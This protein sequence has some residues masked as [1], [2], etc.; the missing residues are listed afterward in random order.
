MSESCAEWRNESNRWSDADGHWRT[1]DGCYLVFDYDL[2]AC[3][4]WCWH[5]CTALDDVKGW[6]RRLTV[7]VWVTSNVGAPGLTEGW[8]GRHE[9]S[10]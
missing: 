10:Q 3:R 8:A 7:D 1:V 4:S 2:T 6:R 5:R 9:G